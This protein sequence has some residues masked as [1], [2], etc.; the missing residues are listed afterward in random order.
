MSLRTLGLTLAGMGLAGLASLA[1]ARAQQTIYA[2]AN[3]GTSLIS[4]Q[5]N[6]P[7]GATL[8][9]NFSGGNT[10][11][12]AIDF[13]PSTG[14]LYGFKSGIGSPGTTVD[15]LYTVNLTNGALTTVGSFGA[16]TN[17]N[18]VGMDFNAAIDRI[19][20]VTDSTQN[21]VI[22]PDTGALQLAATGLTYAAGDVN[23]NANPHV[24]DN[25]YAGNLPGVTGQQYGIDYGTDSL[26]TIANNAGTLTTVGALGVDTDLYTGFD[27]FTS[28]GGVN[29]AYA[30]LG[31]ASGV[32][33]SLYTI[34]LGSGAAT[35][36]G[37]FGSGFTQI[38]S[39]AARPAA[40]AVPEPGALALLI[41]G[42]ATLGLSAC[43]R[44]AA[45]RRA[46]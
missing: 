40:T 25:A 11:L 5:S 24:I 45:R 42:G 8:V 29:T 39:L 35:S 44:R 9:G 2:I 46:V 6:N 4:F 3:G 36:V 17:T 33:E 34:N 10:F 30:I 26:V 18:F 13:R 28:G 43:R 37:T 22:N 16:T 38:Y 14:Q 32:G 7:G 12:D 15:T 31:P 19:R 41:G 21:L 27:I 1:P 20:I 23:V